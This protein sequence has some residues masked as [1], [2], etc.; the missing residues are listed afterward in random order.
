MNRRAFIK[1]A[2]TFTGS[3]LVTGIFAQEK[4]NTP[5]GKRPNIVFILADDMRLDYLECMGMNKNVKTP[6]LNTLAAKGTLFTNGFVTTAACTPSRTSIMTG[7]YER[8]HGITFGSNSAMSENQFS[9]TYPMLLKQAGYFTGYIGKNHTPAGKSE[10]GLGYK[11]GLMEKEFDYWYGGHGH[12]GFYP[13]GKHKIFK[14]VKP[15]TQI[16]IIQK[17]TDNFFDQNPEFAKTKNFLKTRPRDKPF[18]LQINFNVP[19]G[20]GTGSMQMKPTD[21]A[22]YRTTY[23]DQIDH[24]PQPKTYIAEKDIKTPK[25]PTH[26]YNGQYISGYNYV[27][28][29]E[30]LRE[31]QV[32]TCQTVTGI[33]NLV[34]SVVKELEKQGLADNTIIM[35]TSDHG[36]Q[37]GEHGLGG[38]VLLYEESLRVPLIIFDPRLKKS[39]GRKV[40][41]IALTVDFAPTLLELTGNPVPKGMQ[42]HSLKPLMQGDNTNWRND[43]FCENMF[44]GQNYPRMEAVRSG[45]WKYIRYFSKKNDQHHILS[46]IAPL[47]GEKPVYE[48]LYNVQ[49]DPSETKNLAGDKN[50]KEILDQ[51]RKRCNELLKEAK[52]DN[53]LPDTHVKEF[54]KPSFKE[55]VENIYGVLKLK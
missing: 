29:P 28:K 2:A 42:G 35:F 4:E 31:R 12:L 7:Q 21:P 23:R 47:T 24:M 9:Q 25:V 1:I 37:H 55:N 51:Y 53:K 6:N 3:T 15:D 36:L 32:R 54:D 39:H 18:C 14:N 52:G 26:V 8:K 19:H 5:S 48:E 33:D 17:G 10:K 40:K 46:L 34:G 11:S 30:A 16:E 20:A 43:F 27:K 22:L 50:Y 13:K 45:K 49:D 38:K 41:P 44:M